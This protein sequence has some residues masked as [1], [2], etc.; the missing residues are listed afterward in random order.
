M[1]TYTQTLHKTSISETV[2]GITQGIFLSREASRI[3]WL[4][5]A[6]LVSYT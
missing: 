5:T 6:S 2:F 1:G 3:A 4:I